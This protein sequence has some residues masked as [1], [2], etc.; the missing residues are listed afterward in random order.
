MKSIFKFFLV[1][2]FIA[3]APL[4]SASDIVHRFASPSFSKE[5]AGGYWLALHSA[6]MTRKKEIQTK[7]ESDLKAKALEEK[8]S[9]LNKFTT[10]L[11]SRIYS[12]LAQQLTE[13]LF[14]GD[15]D[16][17]TFELDGNTISYEKNIDQIKLSI[18]DGAGG[19]TEIIIPVAAFKF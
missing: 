15:S 17:G 6:Q 3:Y 1:S 5:G 14:S 13:N 7:L 18:D 4:A 8:N 12:Q 19:L 10:N 2:G 11:Q 16:S 9:I